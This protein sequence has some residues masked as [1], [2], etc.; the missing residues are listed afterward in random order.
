[1]L[2]LQE[3]LYKLVNLGQKVLVY[4]EQNICSSKKKEFS[5]SDV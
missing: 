5:T 2:I 1:M 4:V 3:M